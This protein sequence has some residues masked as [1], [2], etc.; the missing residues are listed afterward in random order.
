MKGR[1]APS[2]TGHIHMGNI[3]IAL[4][5][6]IST[7]LQG[8]SFLIRMEDIDLQRSKRSLGEELLD[9]LEWLGFAWDEGPRVSPNGE[10]Y[11][12]SNRYDYY[13][14][15]LEEWQEE[16]R[17]YPCYCNRARLQSI[18]SAPHLGEHQPLYDGHCRDLSSEE[19]ALAALKKAPSYRL[20]VSDSTLTYQDAWQGPQTYHLRAGLDD[21]VL[22]RADGMFAYNLA[23]VLDDAAMGVTEVIR[24]ADLLE[25][26]GQHLYLY[27]VLG[28]EPPTYGHA[29]LLV[30]GEGHRLSKRQQSITVKELREAGYSPN[31][32]WYHLLSTTGLLGNHN[33]LRSG[34]R[35]HNW[36][37]AEILKAYSE[38]TLDLAP[39]H[40]S[41][42]RVHSL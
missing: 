38:G 6:Y 42:I 15:V 32:I 8:G 19:R 28:I 14:A 12:Q 1:F 2:P 5:A 23:V 35:T 20:R 17:I 33:S 29:P 40:Q 24:G 11:W 9:D 21:F 26:T 30:D 36:T 18:A 41:A 37:L 27:K 7:R 34:G 13:N 16:G 4:L 39:L 22:K 10:D 3:W 25:A 31:A